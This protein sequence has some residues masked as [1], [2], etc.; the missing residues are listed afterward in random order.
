MTGEASRDW[1]TYRVEITLPPAARGLGGRLACELHRS[2][3]HIGVITGRH[4]RG[5]YL[6]VLTDAHD[7]ASAHAKA[8]ELVTAALDELGAGDFAPQVEVGEVV[9]RPKLPGGPHLVDGDPGLGYRSTELPDGRVLRA[10]WSSADE[11]WVAYLRENP[12]RVV[13]GRIVTEVVHELL[14][15]PFFGREQWFGPAIEELAGRRTS[16]GVRYPCPCCGYFTLGEPP[17]GTHETCAVC[18]WEDDR[19]QLRDPDDHGGPNKASL[20]EA[21]ETFRRHGVSEE[22]FREHVRLPLPDEQP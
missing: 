6:A 2:D 13:A 19:V 4:E 18:F 17:G 11:E 22:R 14:E 21:R 8:L 16:I 5:V 12:D 7:P 10:A 3:R 15:L 20:N 9:G 1:L